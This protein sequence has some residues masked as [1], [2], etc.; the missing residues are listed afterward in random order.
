[1]EQPDY[2]QTRTWKRLILR[3]PPEGHRSAVALWYRGRSNAVA[4]AQSQ[5]EG[6]PLHL[7]TLITVAVAATLLAVDADPAVAGEPN[8]GVKAEAAT[9][10]VA[11]SQIPSAIYAPMVPNHGLELPSMATLIQP[12]DPGYDQWRAA[13]DAARAK[14]R[15]GMNLT[16]GG[17][18]G[19]PLV[20]GVVA[21]AADSAVGG[22]ISLAGLG[23]GLWG[24]F[25][26]INGHS[27]IGDLELDGTRAGYVSVSP[28]RGG[29]VGTVA[30]SF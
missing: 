23:A 16:F 11:A 29:A 10:D 14:R 30:L 8:K 9:I 5:R 20:G 18:L 3:E 27:D 13:M 1:M 15:R 25:E 26:W 12:A 22:L 17:F 7:K 19:G 6:N 24:I 28:I 4:G 21:A 2:R